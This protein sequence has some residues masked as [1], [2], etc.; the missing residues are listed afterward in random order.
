MT[1]QLHESIYKHLTV[2]FVVYLT[3]TDPLRIQPWAQDRRNQTKSNRGHVRR[4]KAGKKQAGGNGQKS[5]QQRTSTC[6]LHTN[7]SIVGV[8][9]R[10][11]HQLVHGD[12][13]AAPVTGTTLRFT[14]PVPADSRE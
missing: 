7:I 8:E 14:G 2:V 9:K 11:A 13:K 3:L 10:G 4:E 6:P 1:S 12:A 5:S